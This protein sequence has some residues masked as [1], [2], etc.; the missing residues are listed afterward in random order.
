MSP[1]AA[2]HARSRTAQSAFAIAASTSKQTSARIARSLDAG[3]FERLVFR[4]ELRDARHESLDVGGVDLLRDV[5]GAVD[6]PRADRDPHHVVGPDGR[7]A[8]HL[9]APAA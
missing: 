6:V 7:G 8:P 5:L 3:G 4:F 1:I 9:D 2:A